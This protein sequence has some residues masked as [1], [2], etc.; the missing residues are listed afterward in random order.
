MTVAGWMTM[1]L[2]WTLVIGFSIFLIAKTLRLPR[3]PD[4]DDRPSKP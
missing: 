1:G 4:A 3:P 2:C